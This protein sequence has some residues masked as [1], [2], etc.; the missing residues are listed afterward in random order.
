MG[1][2]VLNN[3]RNNHRKEIKRLFSRCSKIMIASP[4][5]SDEAIGFLKDCGPEKFEQVV[6]IITLK[7]KN[8]DRFVGAIISSAN[9]TGNGIERNHEWSVYVEY[10][11]LVEQVYNQVLN[12]TVRSVG[13]QDL[14]DGLAINV[15]VKGVGQ[16][17]G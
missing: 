9:F 13:V 11:V 14:E 16:R 7:A 15:S 4:F 10:E 17:M 2:R 5:I 12:D 8:G 3:T 1:Y 6:L